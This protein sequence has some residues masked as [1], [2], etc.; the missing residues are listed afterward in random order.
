MTLKEISVYLPDEMWI[1]IYSYVGKHPIASILQSRFDLLEI[2]RCTI[3]N[4]GNPQLSNRK[5]VNLHYFSRI[6]LEWCEINGIESN[7]RDYIPKN[8]NCGK[9]FINGRMKYF[10][11]YNEAN[12][13]SMDFEKMLKNKYCSEKVICICGSSIMRKGFKNIYFQTSIRILKI[14]DYYFNQNFKEVQHINIITIYNN[15]N[16][17][18]N[19]QC[20]II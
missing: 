17:N 11:E 7:I 2:H 20:Y 8:N 10:N 14:N 4:M 16:N 9:N 18:D 13:H 15:N 6:N 1:Q 19:I 12:D 3:A 5:L